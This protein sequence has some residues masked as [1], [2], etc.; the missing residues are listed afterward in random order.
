MT[1]THA[2]RSPESQH[3]PV[4]AQQHDSTLATY[5]LLHV[6]CLLGEAC[7]VGLACQHRHYDGVQVFLQQS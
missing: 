1:C 5:A 4:Y 3:D 7:N 2:C 6:P